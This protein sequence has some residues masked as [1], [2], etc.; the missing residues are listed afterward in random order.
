MP[1]VCIELLTPRVTNTKDSK[2]NETGECE[3]GE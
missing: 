2:D 3:L 1:P